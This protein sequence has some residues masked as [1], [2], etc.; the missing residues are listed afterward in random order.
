MC[1][2]YFVLNLENSIYLCIRAYIKAYH[3]VWNDLPSI[4]VSDI[5]YGH[6]RHIALITV[7]D[8]ICLRIY[9]CGELPPLLNVPSNFHI[10]GVL[11]ASVVEGIVEDAVPAIV[12]LHTW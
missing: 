1:H 7:N 11:K 2:F 8:D 12:L 5:W 10:D 9:I 6:E 4:L 3:G